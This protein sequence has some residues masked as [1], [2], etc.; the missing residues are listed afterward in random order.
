MPK[1]FLVAGREFHQHLRSRGFWLATLG[2]PLIFAVIWVITGGTMVVDPPDVKLPDQP[3]GYVDQAGL[4]R[5]IPASIPTELFRPFSDQAAA[6]TALERGEIE[7]YY[8]ISPDYRETGQV[9][10]VSLRF[11]VNP[12]DVRWFNQL[13]QA[14]LVPDIAPAQ[15]ERLRQPFNAPQP[16]YINVTPAGQTDNSGNPL[17]PLVVTMAIIT[18]LFSG[19]SYLFQSLAQEKSNRIMEMLLVSLKPVQLLT[20]KIIG[21]SLLTLLQYLVWLLF[22]GMGLLAT[23]QN[24]GQ[25]LN[26]LHL[27]GPQLLLVIP[28]AL[29]GYL[30]YAALMAGIGALGRDVE[31]GRAWLLV[32]SLPVMAPLFLGIFI[33]GDP[34]GLLA[35]SLSLFPFSAPA[36]M[37][38]R[39][40]STV[41]PAWQITLS[42]LLL[43]LTGI[44]TIWLMARL[45]HIQMLLSGESLS[46]RRIWAALTG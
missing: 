1:T 19:V 42:L 7:A 43:G 29:G 18:P 6:E 27:S 22:W 10:R 8:L 20:G 26:A 46:I 21:L 3:A 4:I 37:L 39:I 17:I 9:Q 12:P 28:Y 30:L 35:V 23:G 41:V 11:T 25:L 31:D 2:I 16:E 34:H 40:T 44:G 13:L 38:L 45:F 24:G 32:V 15:L 5:A 14:S 33:A 36:G